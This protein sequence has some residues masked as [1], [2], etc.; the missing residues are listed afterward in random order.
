[1]TSNS[2]RHSSK[3]MRT[4]TRDESAV[5][6]KTKEKYGGLS[7]MAGGYPLEVNNIRI[8]T[9][10]A[11]YQACRFPNNEKWQ[12][13]I[14]AERSP[15][16]AKM[17]SKPHRKDSRGD[18]D[19]VRVMIMRWCLRVKLVQNWKEFSELLQETE[20]KDIVEESRK[21][22]FWGA[23]PQNDGTLRGNNVLGRLLMELREKYQHQEIQA[24]EKINPPKISDFKLYGEFIGVVGADADAAGTT[25]YESP[26]TRSKEAQPELQF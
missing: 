22:D 15:M 14:I 12:R 8:L 23:K 20:G 24:E 1:M 25:V 9:S 7:N 26:K 3:Q 17:K 19:D 18:W 6:R 13:E 5:F 4:Y 11:L 16:A 21:D 2:D 10:E